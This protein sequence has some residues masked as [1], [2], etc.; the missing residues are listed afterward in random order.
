MQF[1]DRQHD[2]LRDAVTFMDQVF[3]LR[4]KIDEG[5][6][7]LTAIPRIDQSGCVGARDTML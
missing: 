5:N 4:V 1:I 2:K 6:F 3:I 7:H